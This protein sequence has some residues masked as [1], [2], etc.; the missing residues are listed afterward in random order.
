LGSVENYTPL[1]GTGTD[2]EF[3]R[4][5]YFLVEIDSSQAYGYPDDVS[6]GPTIDDLTLFFTSDPNKRLRHGKTFTGGE[7]QPLDTPPGP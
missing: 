3:A 7:K 5:F 6:R 4:Y 2:T 1:D